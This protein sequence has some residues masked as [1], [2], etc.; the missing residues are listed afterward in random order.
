MSSGRTEPS[1][2][3]IEPGGELGELEQ[4]VMDHVWKHSPVSAEQCRDAVAPTLKDSTIRTVLR[5][6]EEKGYVE[7]E[8]S[9]RTYLYRPARARHDV[10]A[11][12]VQKIVDRFCDGSVERLLV[13]LVDNDV[14]TQAELERLARKIA[15]AKEGRK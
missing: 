15:R 13:G 11:R 12:A 10:A 2:P 14:V 1:P 8:V 4:A 5:R 6:L 3:A 9:G 7:H